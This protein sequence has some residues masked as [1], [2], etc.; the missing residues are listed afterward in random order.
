MSKKEDQEVLMYPGTELA[1]C[2]ADMVEKIEVYK[3]EDRVWLIRNCM[4]LTGVR[5]AIL[6]QRD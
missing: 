4:R 3:M 6:D 2:L 1:N 5:K